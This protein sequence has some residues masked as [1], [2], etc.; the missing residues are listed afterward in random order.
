MPGW[1]FSTSDRCPRGGDAGGRRERAAARPHDVACPD[2][3]RCRRPRTLGPR[4]RVEPL[5]PAQVDRHALALGAL[6]LRAYPADH[7]DAFDGDEAAAVSQLRAIARG[8][9]LGLMMA[10]SRIALVDGRIAG[11]CLVVDRPGDPPHSGPWVIDIFRDPDCPVRGVGTALLGAVLRAARRGRAARALP[12][13]QP[14]QR[15]SPGGSTGGSASPRWTRAGRSPSRRRT[16]AQVHSMVL[17]AVPDQLTFTAFQ[18]A[19][20]A[21]YSVLPAPYSSVADS[22]VP[23]RAWA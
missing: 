9:L 6:N 5:T 3:C 19:A 14:R 8:E 4:L 10:E 20:T 15:R 21:L 17:L 23:A 7:P 18:A 16:S 1:R 11:A 13:G 12:R 22:R 2:R